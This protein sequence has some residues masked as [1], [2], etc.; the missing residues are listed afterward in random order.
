MQAVK[1]I[2]HNR[3]IREIMS[4]AAYSAHVFIHSTLTVLTRVSAA[5]KA[6]ASVRR[7]S[8]LA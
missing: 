2:A 6:A 8:V 1:A 5:M 4:M 7:A 3:V